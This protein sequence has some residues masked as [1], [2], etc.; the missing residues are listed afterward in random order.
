MYSC[1]FFKT[2]ESEM[3]VGLITMNGKDSIN[4]NIYQHKQNYKQKKDVHYK[5]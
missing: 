1:N 3:F 4:Q 2:E 5:F